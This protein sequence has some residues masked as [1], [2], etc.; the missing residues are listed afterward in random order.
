MYSDNDTSDNSVA[1]DRLERQERMQAEAWRYD[2]SLEEA[3]RLKADHPGEYR[4]L[5][6]GTKMAVGYYVAGKAA[7]RKLGMDT[8]G[9]PR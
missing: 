4:Q 5:A 1:K 3:L 9:G 7:A 6:P 2:A 8:S